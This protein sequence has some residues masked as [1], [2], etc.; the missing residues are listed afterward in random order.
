MFTGVYWPKSNP[1]SSVAWFR[2]DATTWANN[3]S[4]VEGPSYSVRLFVFEMPEDE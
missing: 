2:G 1:S 3:Y 4:W